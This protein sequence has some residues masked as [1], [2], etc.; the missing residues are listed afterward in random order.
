[1]RAMTSYAYVRDV[2][3]AEVV[4]VSV[5][6]LNSKYLDV[7]IRHLP[8]E[9]VL[10]ERKI[11]ELIENVIHRGRLEL[12]VTVR[13]AKS[14]KTEINKDLLREY[15]GQIKKIARQMHLP[16]SVSL[17][18]LLTLPGLIS[19]KSTRSI[20]EKL[21]LQAVKKALNKTVSFRE[22]EGRAIRKKLIT[23][24]RALTRAL[25]KI[26]QYKP[27]AGNSELGKEDI[28]EEVSLLKFYVKKLDKIMHGKNKAVS[29]KTIDFLAQEILRELNTSAS[30]SKKVHLASVII[31]AK[32]YTERIREQAQNIE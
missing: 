1:M 9:N 7:Y 28:D 18:D 32:N 3:G 13:S 4:E 23:H 16:E 27:K 15:Y 12:N 10:L 14:D 20:N 8:P 21:V 6:T 26:E 30:K 17:R 29:G 11:K 25:K 31:E 19:V 2:K 22:K 24:L 5:K